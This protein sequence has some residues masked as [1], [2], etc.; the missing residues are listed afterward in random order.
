M[1][2]PT[3]EIQAQTRARL[4]RALKSQGSVA[5]ENE[6]PSNIAYAI[7]VTYW[8]VYMKSVR[9]EVQIHTTTNYAGLIMR[10]QSTL[11]MYASVARRGNTVVRMLSVQAA[12]LGNVFARLGVSAAKTLKFPHTP[13]PKHRHR[14]SEVIVGDNGLLLLLHGFLVVEAATE[15]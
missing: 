9:C 14:K 7:T 8:K 11:V 15:W 5:T 6:C 10:A 12:S 4:E 13:H 2:F 3:I 1:E